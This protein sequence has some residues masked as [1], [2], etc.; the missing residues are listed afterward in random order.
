[1]HDCNELFHGVCGKQLSESCCWSL[2]SISFRLEGFGG[3]S[4]LNCTKAEMSHLFSLNVRVQLWLHYMHIQVHRLS[5]CVCMFEKHSRIRPL[6]LEMCVGE[7]IPFSPQFGRLPI[8]THRPAL[9]NHTTTSFV[10]LLFMLRNRL[11]KA[12][13][14]L[15]PIHDL[16]D[17]RDWL[18]S[19]CLTG[20]R[21]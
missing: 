7:K 10:E 21:S 17:A 1:M 5:V 18:A 13:P 14:T 2:N 4:R 19:L 3:D 6:L 8:P 15:F 16:A 20:E 12:L 11:E 9:S